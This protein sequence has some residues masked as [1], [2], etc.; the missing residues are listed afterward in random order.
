M[1]RYEPVEIETK[2]LVSG[3]W[4]QRIQSEAHRLL[5]QLKGELLEDSSHVGRLC[6]CVLCDVV[7]IGG[8]EGFLCFTH[9]HEIIAG[10]E[11]GLHSRGHAADGH[12]RAKIGEQAMVQEVGHGAQCGHAFPHRGQRVVVYADGPA[13]LLKVH[14]VHGHFGDEPYGI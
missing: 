10:I 11:E 12:V 1:G 4:L 9:R 5:V 14:G 8:N 3:V 7:H 13:E 6:A 2:F